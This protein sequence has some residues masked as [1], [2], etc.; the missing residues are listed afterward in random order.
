MQLLLNRNVRLVVLLVLRLLLNEQNQK[1]RTEL[2][3][4]LQFF[5]DTPCIKN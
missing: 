3:M 5:S 4:I 1:F 2:D